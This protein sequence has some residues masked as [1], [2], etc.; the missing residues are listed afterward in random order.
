MD[1][2]RP[3]NDTELIPTLSLNVAVN[4]T[5][6]DWSLVLRATLVVLAES[7]DAF[8]ALVIEGLW[9]SLLLILIVI[10][11]VILFPAESSA[12]AVSVSVLAPKL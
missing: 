5:V 12:V 4:V 7:P 2:V 11:S 3:P 8:P 6:L 1:G 10:S 9:L